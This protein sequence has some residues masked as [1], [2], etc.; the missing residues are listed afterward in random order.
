MYIVKGQ[1]A[2][3]WPALHFMEQETEAQAV[4][5]ALKGFLRG[6]HG[7][8]DFVEILTEFNVATSEGQLTV[9]ED[10]LNQ[11]IRDS[12]RVL[13][14]V[15]GFTTLN[16]QRLVSMCSSFEIATQ[17]FLSGWLQARPADAEALA[18]E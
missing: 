18:R 17:D 10:T 7:H 12:W 4:F 11:R 6:T 8:K 9:S 16:V 5:G 1:P 2:W 14:E 13:F 3:L 15:H